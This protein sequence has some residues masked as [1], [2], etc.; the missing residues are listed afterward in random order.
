MYQDPALILAVPQEFGTPY[1]R[2]SS[3]SWD[4]W[5]NEESSNDSMESP[6]SLTI[7]KP[8]TEVKIKGYSSDFL[9]LA[10]LD[11]VT[12]LISWNLYNEPRVIADT[13]LRYH[14]DLDSPERTREFAEY[15]RFRRC[16]SIE[17]N[18][19]ETVISCS[20]MGVAVMP[21]RDDYIYSALV[22]ESNKEAVAWVGTSELYLSEGLRSVYEFPGIVQRNGNCA[23]KIKDR[24]PLDLAY[25]M[26]SRFES[27]GLFNL[28]TCA[29]NELYLVGINF[30][31][32][33][34]EIITEDIPSDFI[35]WSE[36]LVQQMNSLE[37]SELDSGLLKYHLAL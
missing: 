28:A 8:T 30:N 13:M 19:S 10:N 9:E 31:Y 6:I 14:L 1:F 3:L 15:I 11:K 25:Q 36:D 18:I 21:S 32:D 26:A 29:A 2:F 35:D 20:A 24:L 23:I 34:S 33:T 22:V 5:R 7:D 17:K 37:I 27:F 12:Q 16:K 4:W